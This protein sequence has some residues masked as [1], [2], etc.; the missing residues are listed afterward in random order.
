M[1]PDHIGRQRADRRISEKHNNWDI[2]VHTFADHVMYSDKRYR[3]TANLKEIVVDAYALDGERLPP[4]A[5]DNSFQLGSGRD[6]SAMQFLSAS[7]AE[8]I[9]SDQLCRSALGVTRE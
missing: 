2:A 8:A 9:R 1:L 7:A 3:I 6:M 4:Y 5:R